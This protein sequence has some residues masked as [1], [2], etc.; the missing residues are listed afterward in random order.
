MT[1][2]L[3]YISSVGS[4]P[5]ARQYDPL[6]LYGEKIIFDVFRKG[7]KAGT[8]IVTFSRSGEQLQVRSSFDLSI[9]FLSLNVYNFLYQS[10]E[11]WF[12]D[13]LQKIQVEVD[14]NGEKETLRVE[15]LNGDLKVIS[16]DKTY[17]INGSVFPTTHWNSG[18]LSQKRVLNTLTGSLNAVAI[19]SV[20]SEKLETEK[21]QILAKRYDYSGDLQTSVWYD[22]AGRWVKMQFSAKD[23]S[24]ITYKCRL[25]QG[26]D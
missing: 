5:T 22:N 21:G 17:V 7:E 12:E 9:K 13:R 6:R 8:H 3:L 11:V 18:V 10:E 24:D 15:R 4:A 16:K 25:C 26:P 1:L 14:D 2:S 23:G 19:T 20:G